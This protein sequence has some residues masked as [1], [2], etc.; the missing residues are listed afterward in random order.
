MLPKYK[1]RRNNKGK[2]REIIRMKMKKT[3]TVL[4]K[5]SATTS[6]TLTPAETRREAALSTSS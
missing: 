5:T 6:P 4:G 2:G 3:S 1:Q